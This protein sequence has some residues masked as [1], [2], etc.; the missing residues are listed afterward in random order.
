MVQLGRRPP[1]T[2]SSTTELQWIPERYEIDLSPA[3]SIDTAIHLSGVPIAGWLW[4]SKRKKIISNS[5][6]T[7]TR[8][9]TNALVTSIQMPVLFI[10][11]SAAGFYGNRQEEILDESSPVGN[12]F[13]AKTADQ[14]ELQT[15]VAAEAKAREEQEKPAGKFE[16]H[17]DSQVR[18]ESARGIC[19]Q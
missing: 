2:N 1:T 13:L 12:G 16:R 6:I 11:A 4:T 10:T 5:R 3:G 15:R 14:W 17:A 9:L 18:V 8:L 19:I 7:P